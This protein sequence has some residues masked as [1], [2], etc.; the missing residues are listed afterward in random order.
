MLRPRTIAVG[1]VAAA[2]GVAFAAVPDPPKLRANPPVRVIH[3]TGPGMSSSTITLANQTPDPV[4]IAS[5]TR[6]PSCDDEVTFALP[7]PTTIP[8]NGSTPITIQCAGTVMSG[9]RR[10]MFHANPAIGGVLVDFEA[11]CEGGNQTTLGASPSD[12]DFGDVVIGS[13]AS[14]TVMVTNDGA[15]QISKLSLHATDLDSTFELGA[16]CNPDARECDTSIATIANG[17]ATPITVLCRPKRAG[18]HTAELHVATSTTGQYLSPPITLACNGIA[19]ATP[20]LAIT[21]DPV[22]AGRVDVITGNAS[23]MPLRLRN[24]GVGMLQI[25]NVQIFDNGNGAAADWSYT[26]SGEC[27]GSV[28]PVCELAPDEV[29]SLRLELDPSAIGARDATL[30]IEYFDT[31]TRSRSI[32]LEGDGLGATLSLVGGATVLDFGTVPINITSDLPFQ[33]ANQGNRSIATM[34]QAVPPPFSLVPAASINVVPGTPGTIVAS[35]R[36]T[37]IGQFA[38][39]IVAEGSD[40]FMSGSGSIEIPATCEGT[41]STLYSAPSSVMLGQVRVSDDTMAIPIQILVSSG[42]QLQIVSAGLATPSELLEVDASLPMITPSTVQLEVSP[43]AEGDL[44]NELVILA[45]NGATV[46]IPISGSIATAEYEQPLPRSLGTFCVSQPT[47]SDTLAFRST[48]TATLEL[49]TPTMAL[50]ALS[51]FD[52][53]PQAPPSYP[54][55]LSP[56]STAAV[57]VTPRRQG[58]AGVQ[59]DDVVWTTDVDGAETART[60]ISARFVDDGGAIAP[61]ALSFGPGTIHLEQDNAQKVTLQNCDTQTIVFADPS[62]PPPFRLD[63]ANFP[64][65]LAPNESATFTIGFHPTRVGLFDETLTIQSDQLDEPLTVRLT[66]EGAKPTLPP[67]AGVENPSIGEQSFYGCTGCSTREPAGG[68]LILIAL[69]AALSRR[70]RP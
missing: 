62:V 20:V 61:D 16:P 51:P 63:S 4:T 57:E 52:V 48:G 27:S 39:T 5:I 66:G 55:L 15:T 58:S 43:S 26:A 65:M 12:L 41:N 17:S 6:D 54:V 53:E 70:R 22:D 60:T 1:V 68:A 14:T 32:P 7:L 11:V 30:V 50:G 69:G 2:V 21:G 33:L 29:L 49:Q 40:A 19:P 36:P 24:A 42:A 47:T 23:P 31:A 45:S 67:D 25:T 35:C 56:A 34:L 10:C 8:G 38:T 9:L 59:Q 46:R 37:A 13:S 18:A 64:R 3:V 28:P 44:A